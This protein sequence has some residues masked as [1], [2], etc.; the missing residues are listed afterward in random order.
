[1]KRVSFKF[2][3]PVNTLCSLKLKLLQT[4]QNMQLVNHVAKQMYIGPCKRLAVRTLV[5]P[6]AATPTR[7]LRA[8]R[9]LL[10]GLRVH[11]CACCAS[12]VLLL[13]RLPACFIGALVAAAGSTHAA[14]T[15]ARESISMGPA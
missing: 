2:I 8:P 3:V 9:L 10:L 5:H 13:L 11:C 1:M 7:I 6:R 15:P 12:S 4:A 14:A